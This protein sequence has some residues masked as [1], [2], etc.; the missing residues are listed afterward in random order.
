MKR[1]YCFVLL[2]LLSGPCFGGTLVQ[3]R[4]VL[5]D[6]DVELYDQDKP[7]TV[8]NFIRYIQSGRYEGIFL[9]RCIPGFILQGGRYLTLDPNINDFLTPQNTFVYQAFPAITNEYAV[10]RRLSNTNWT[11][12]MTRISGQTNSAASEW[13]FN[14]GNNADLDNVD[15]G[16]TVFGQ[17]LRG[18]NV[19]GYFNTLTLNFGVI[20]MR[21]YFGPGGFGTLFA[22]LPVAYFGQAPPRVNQLYYVDISLLNVKVRLDGNRARE[23]SWRS[24]LDRPNHVQFTTNFPPVWQTLATKIGNGQTNSVVDSSTDSARRFYRVRVD[25]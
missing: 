21:N 8:Q 23:I 16:F 9:H 20:D 22:T 14:L 12:A 18:T 13:F 5:G 17:T 4:T 25:Y 10:G 3:F 24:V 7:V 15:G 6:I 19:L 2:T 11:L 1:L